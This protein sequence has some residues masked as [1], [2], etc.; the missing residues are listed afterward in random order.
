MAESTAEL[1]LDLERPGAAWGPVDPDVSAPLPGTVLILDG[2]RRIDARVWVHGGG[3]SR[4]RASPPRWPP[5]SSAVP[6]GGRPPD[7]S[8]RRRGHAGRRGGRAR[9]VHVRAAGRRHR[10]PG[11]RCIPP[12]PRPARGPTSSRWRCSDG[13][14]T[15]RSGSRPPSGPGTPA[16]MTC[17]SSTGRCAAAPTWT[18]PWVT[19]R[20]TTPPT[21]LTARPRWSP[22]CARAADPG[23][24]D[25]HLVAAALLVPAAAGYRA[26]AVVGHRPDRMLGRPAAGRRDRG[27][28]PDRARCCRRWPVPRTRTRAHRRTWSRSA[29]WSASCGAGSATSNCSTGRCGRPQWPAAE[30]SRPAGFRRASCGLAGN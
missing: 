11:R 22:R 14:P 18:A 2:V 4:P 23:L 5:G 25:G 6:P 13:C 3:R 30:P 10:G 9:P 17:W 20:R 16:V 29:A 7:P 15:P 8:L 1:N 27:R 12:S 28:R 19:S 26:G 24:H 21:F